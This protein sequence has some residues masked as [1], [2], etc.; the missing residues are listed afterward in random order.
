[1]KISPPLQIVVNWTAGLWQEYVTYVNNTLSHEKSNKNKLGSRT[2]VAR[3]FFLVLCVV[4]FCKEDGKKS[5]LVNSLSL[6]LI[7][8]E[9]G[10]ADRRAMEKIP[11][12]GESLF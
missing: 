7:L 3:Y 1:M 5:S 4:H 8:C 11:E 10:G 6:T 9:E 12:W 2:L